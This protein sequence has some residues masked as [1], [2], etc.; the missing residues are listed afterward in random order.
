MRRIK[1]S[2]VD[3]FPA[4]YVEYNGSLE[5]NMPWLLENYPDLVLQT[6]KKQTVSEYAEQD[7]E[8]EEEEEKSKKKKGGGGKKKSGDGRVIIERIERRKRKYVT[9]IVGLEYYDIKVKPAA[10]DMGKK[11]ASGSTV[12]KNAHNQK[13]I[14]IQGDVSY[15]VPDFIIQQWPQIPKDSLYF[16]EK[17]KKSKCF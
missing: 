16:L 2:P 15:D 17:G 4:E 9:S 13:T 11:F 5:E 1:Y 12:T 14:D 7:G 6:K 3:G 10:K 8:G